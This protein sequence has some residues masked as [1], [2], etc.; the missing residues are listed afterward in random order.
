MKINYDLKFKEELEKIK[1]KAVKNHNFQE[2]QHDE[3]IDS[4]F[5]K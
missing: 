1:A 5:I 2:L 4:K 3:K